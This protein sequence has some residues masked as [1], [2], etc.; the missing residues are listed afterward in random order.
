VFQKKKK[1][2]RSLRGPP[3]HDPEMGKRKT[4]FSSSSSSS[5]SSSYF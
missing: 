4:S 2:Q 5:S 1:T 3:E